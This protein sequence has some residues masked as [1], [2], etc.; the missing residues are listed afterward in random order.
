MFTRKLERFAYFLRA[1]VK[2]FNKFIKRKDDLREQN[3]NEEYATY[4]HR[5]DDEGRVEFTKNYQ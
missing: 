2:E 1:G 3:I 5:H 4:V